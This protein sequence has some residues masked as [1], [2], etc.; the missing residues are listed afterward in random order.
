MM[1]S[2]CI[3]YLPL[4]SDGP[5]LEAS[6][7]AKCKSLN[8]FWHIKNYEFITICRDQFEMDIIVTKALSNELENYKR[9]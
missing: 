4:G 5:F 8:V 7:L 2:Y 9:E 3:H 1:V 6:Y